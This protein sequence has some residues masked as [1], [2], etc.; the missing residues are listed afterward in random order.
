[1]ENPY[2]K[3]IGHPDD[4]RYPLDLEAVVKA[5]KKHGKLL[6]LNNSSLKPG[7]SRI[8]VR[9]NDLILLEHCKHYEVPIIMGSDAHFMNA[10][11][12]HD[13]ALSLIEEANFPKDLVA[14]Y[15]MELLAKYIPAVQE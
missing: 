11:G 9:E 6:E 14:N 13:L 7:G 2:V 8:Q 1:M 3:I 5:A 15:S 10:V 4:G 12:V